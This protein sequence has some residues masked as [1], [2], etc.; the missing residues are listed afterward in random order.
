MRCRRSLLFLCSSFAELVVEQAGEVAWRMRHLLRLSG[1]GGGVGSGVFPSGGCRRL[2]L[3]IGF[4]GVFIGLGVGLREPW[5]RFVFIS[6]AAIGMEIWSLPLVGS[7]SSTPAF[8]SACLDCCAGVSA[9]DSR[10]AYT[11]SVPPSSV[12]RRQPTIVQRT[13]LWPG[14]N[15]VLPSLAAYLKLGCFC[16]GGGWIQLRSVRWWVKRLVGEDGLGL[17]VFSSFCRVLCVKGEGPDVIQSIPFAKKKH[18][19]HRGGITYSTGTVVR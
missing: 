8:S 3:P 16:C 19:R 18:I 9:S 11:V 5:V 2:L 15:P 4:F 1:G 13:K 14:E 17:S 7:V 10:A 6:F 12:A